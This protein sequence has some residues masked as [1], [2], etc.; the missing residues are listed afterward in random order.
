MF[1]IEEVMST[2]IYNFETSEDTETVVNFQALSKI[3][4]F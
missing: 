3:T 2:K 1:Q 4:Q